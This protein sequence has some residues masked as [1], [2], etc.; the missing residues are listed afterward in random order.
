MN[1]QRRI[2]A[3]FCIKNV[4]SDFATIAVVLL[5][6]PTKFINKQAMFT[7]DCGRGKNMLY[8]IYQSVLLI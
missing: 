1:K 3:A 8:E 5:S 2:L 6:R 7:A 4:S